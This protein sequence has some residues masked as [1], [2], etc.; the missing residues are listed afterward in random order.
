M[1]SFILASRQNISETNQQTAHKCCLC[2]K[3]VSWF[4]SSSLVSAHVFRT[5]E[6]LSLTP[7]GRGRNGN[8]N[9][10]SVSAFVDFFAA[11]SVPAV[12]YLAHP[13]RWMNFRK[14]VVSCHN[15][16]TNI[17]LKSEDAQ[18]G[19]GVVICHVD[20]H[21]RSDLLIIS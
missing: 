6:G 11:S 13:G 21:K 20:I 15:V 1:A 12:K 4:I 16:R 2:A 10:S 8:A 17:G 3:R 5:G 14:L 9:S 18:F 7:S 19:R